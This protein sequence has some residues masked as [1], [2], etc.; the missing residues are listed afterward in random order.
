MT[1]NRYANLEARKPKLTVPMY[2]ELFTKHIQGRDLNPAPEASTRILVNRINLLRGNLE[3][4]VRTLLPE[5]TKNKELIKALDTASRLVGAQIANVK[6]TIEGIR[7][8]ATPPLGEDCDHPG[9]KKIQRDAK[10]AIEER[11]QGLIGARS[12][13][14]SVDALRA[15]KH[16][17]F[18]IT[19]PDF[20]TGWPDVI[21]DLVGPFRDAMTPTN[22]CEQFK[23]SAD[24]PVAR[25]LA[26]VMP[27][28]TGEET[29]L[30]GPKEGLKPSAFASEGRRRGL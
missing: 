28:V 8:H 3:A 12:F 18:P 6:H 1:S 11:E 24:G 4:F 27:H 14:Q 15:N 26:A 30:G 21:G 29:A 7:Q 5:I 22:P 17:V 13:L 23:M 20:P 19:K 2:N 25:F 9:W 10:A 16:F